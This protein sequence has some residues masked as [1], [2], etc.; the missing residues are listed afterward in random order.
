[1]NPTANKSD[2]EDLTTNLRDLAYSYLEKIQPIK[3][4]TKST[5]IKKIFN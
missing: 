1:M 3:T 4:T 5:F 2:F